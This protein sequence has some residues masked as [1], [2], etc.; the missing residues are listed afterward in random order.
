LQDAACTRYVA[1]QA[2]SIIGR[3][4]SNPTFLGCPAPAVAMSVLYACRLASGVAPS[5]PFPLSTMLG[6]HCPSQLLQP[7]IQAALQ[8][9]MER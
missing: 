3:A 9:V 7:Y 6:M 5:W 1:G 4:V 2:L 8:L